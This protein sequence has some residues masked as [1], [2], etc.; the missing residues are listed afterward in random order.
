MAR[1]RATG[2]CWI[3]TATVSP[4][5]VVA[6]YRLREAGA[7][8]R[9]G[10]YVGEGVLDVHAE[11]LEEGGAVLFERTD[12]RAVHEGAE[13]GLEGLGRHR[14]DAD[15]LTRLDVDPPVL[16]AEL[17]QPCGYPGPHD[18]AALPHVLLVIS[19]PH[20]STHVP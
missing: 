12:P 17:P 11:V 15:V 2:L 1:N 16:F 7:R 3:L 10:I 4:P 20:A 5:C 9:G 8:H 13:D 18:L 19:L 14:L 6:R